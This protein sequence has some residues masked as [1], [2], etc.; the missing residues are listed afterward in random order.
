M[1]IK[2]LDGIIHGILKPWKIDT[3]NTRRFNEL[4]K[5]SK[6]ASTNTNAELCTKLAA[7][8]I[9][10]P[11]LQD[12]ITNEPHN[13]SQ[14]KPLLFNVNLPKYKDGIT[15]FYYIL[16]TNETLRIYNAILD[17]SVEWTELIDIRYQVGKILT[18]LR[19]LA[20]QV[21]L[22]LIEQRYTAI[23]DSSSNVVHLRCIFLSIH[24]LIYTSAYKKL[25]NQS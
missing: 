16:I 15:Q 3:T 12:I 1:Q 21:S 20:K 6:A 13:N 8:L 9:D 22:E 10:F 11:A 5:A 19:V 17:Q 25:L 14:I 18:D 24:L 7:L 4:V 2:I 23:P